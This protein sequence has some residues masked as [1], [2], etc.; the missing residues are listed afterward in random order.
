MVYYTI[1]SFSCNV[2]AQLPAGLMIIDGGAVSTANASPQQ[3]SPFRAH[4]VDAVPRKD[5]QCNVCTECCT[6]GGGYY[7][8][9]GAHIAFHYTPVLA[10]FATSALRASIS[11]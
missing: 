9:Y 6:F 7:T 2:S 1:H 5:E 8:S 3:V 4:S 10:D 11:I